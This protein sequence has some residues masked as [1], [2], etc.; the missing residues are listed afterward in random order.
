[1]TSKKKRILVF[2]IL[3]I[4]ILIIL[5]YFR[6][7]DSLSESSRRPAVIP[8]VIVSKP[9]IGEI[10]STLSLTGDINPIQQANIYSRV[11]GNIQ[12]IY[13]DIGEPVRQGKLLALIDTTIYSQNV[14]Q[15]LASLMQAEAN[16]QN[17]KMNYERNRNLLTQNLIAKQ[18]VDNSKTAYDIA[19]AQKESANAMYKNAMT[20]LN[21]CKITA[22]F[23]GIITKR[24]L[25]PGA[26]VSAG[27]SSP[28][29]VLFILMDI[30]KV[31]V[32][33]NVPEKELPSLTK[34]EEV[35]IKTGAYPDKVFSGVIQRSSQSLDLA[36][37]TMLVE[38]D[39]ENEE[40]LLKPGMFAEISLVL[41]RKQNILTLPSN[42]LM[43]DDS[44]KYV[45][46]LTHDTVALKKYVTIGLQDE[47]SSEIISG[48]QESDK[49][50]SV[51]QTMIK[52]KMK[53]RIAK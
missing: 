32:L 49:F 12:K 2:G 23:S 37:R 27:T 21:Y 38:I 47:N 45:F 30:E 4:I 14:R 48:L 6:I 17:A 46:M 19:V 42:V 13:C 8:S 44:G 31:K 15:A 29:S 7:M 1:M 5:A 10:S 43:S 18:D 25:D 50:V 40:H 24:Y 39:I 28:S 26:Y 11:S 9:V 41:E 33:A 53:V 52:D 16:L 3:S 20:Q 34:V 35:D 36:T 22:P 51:G